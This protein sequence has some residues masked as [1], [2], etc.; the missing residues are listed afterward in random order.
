M[1][2]MMLYML[3]YRDFI[4]F[5][6][7]HVWYIC[8]S[9]ID[10]I[11]KLHFSSM[12][13]HGFPCQIRCGITAPL[14]AVDVQCW[15]IPGR[16]PTLSGNSCAT[17]GIMVGISW[18]RSWFW[19]CGCRLIIYTI[20]ASR[21]NFVIIDCRWDG[22]ILMSWAV[23]VLRTLCDALSLQNNIGSSSLR[24]CVHIPWNFLFWALNR[25]S[26]LLLF[27]FENTCNLDVLPEFIGDSNT[28]VESNF[29]HRISHCNISVD[30]Y[31]NA[32]LPN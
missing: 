21:W 3:D 4:V 15:F 26:D 17:N 14:A 22:R 25:H 18:M 8:A 9:S 30:S 24:N 16:C 13:H 20:W 19:G 32:Y 1:L 29:F 31:S 5:I 2:V 10:Y 28:S 7:W 11:S 6:Y 27:G 23:L 12:P